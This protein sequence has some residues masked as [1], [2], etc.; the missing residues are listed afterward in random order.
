MLYHL[1]FVFNIALPI[2][3]IWFFRQEKHALAYDNFLNRAGSAT[4][5]GKG[6]M[7][8]MTSAWYIVVY[9]HLWMLYFAC[10]L[11]MLGLSFLALSFVCVFMML[12]PIT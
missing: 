12:L 11:D 2:F 1:L 10:P 9:V 8:G 4:G 7:A 5:L 6:R 3:L